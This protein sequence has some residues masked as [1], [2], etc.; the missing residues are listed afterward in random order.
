MGQFSVRKPALHSP[1]SQYDDFVY[2]MFSTICLWLFTSQLNKYPKNHP[3]LHIVSHPSEIWGTTKFPLQFKNL[4][5]IF[6]TKDR[7]LGRDISPKRNEVEK[8]NCI[9][10]TKVH[11][12][13]AYS[14][15][16]M[17]KTEG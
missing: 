12:S 2:I 8:V 17:K 3:I 6:S 4:T 14:D 11:C 13:K 1:T 5:K 7:Y 10:S 15:S 9:H 16:Q